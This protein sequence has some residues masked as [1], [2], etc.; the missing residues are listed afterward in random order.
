MREQRTARLL[1]E[2]AEAPIVLVAALAVR[3]VGILAHDWEPR[4]P[5]RPDGRDSVRSG[6][7]DVEHGHDRTPKINRGLIRGLTSGWIDELDVQRQRHC[8]ANEPIFHQVR[9]VARVVPV[10]TKIVG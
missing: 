2:R 8:H 4:W 6:D 9:E 5:W 1:L 3:A 10:H 7:R